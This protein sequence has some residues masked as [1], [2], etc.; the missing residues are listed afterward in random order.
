MW[1]PEGPNPHPDFVCSKK[2]RAP[3]WSWASCDGVVRF[4]KE[5]STKLLI[6]IIRAEITPTA[7]NDRFGQVIDGLIQ[8]EGHL[9]KV[10][11]RSWHFDDAYEARER[12]LGLDRWET[13]YLLVMR[14]QP[15]RSSLVLELTGN[16]P[17]QYIRRGMLLMNLG[18]LLIS[19]GRLKIR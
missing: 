17:G 15:R 6:D 16:A 10:R 3:S 9:E 8:L 5:D 14:T 1:G 12:N 4:D 7:N 13:M 19:T 2:Y 18:K 11:I